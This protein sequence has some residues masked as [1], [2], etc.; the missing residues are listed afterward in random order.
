MVSSREGTSTWSIVT[1][2]ARVRVL[3]E[4]A[5][6]CVELLRDPLRVVEPLDPQHELAAAVALV[7]LAGDAR[8]LRIAQGRAEA[9]DVDP[10]RM[11]ADPD[12]AV[13][14]LDRVG[15]GSIPSTRRHEDRKWRA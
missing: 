11:D 14:L 2:S 1:S 10:D 8:R 4:Q 15:P 9:L 5:L 7:E 6:E 3:L 12:R 13:V